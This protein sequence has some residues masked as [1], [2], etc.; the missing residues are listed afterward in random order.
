M[1]IQAHKLLELHKADSHE[2]MVDLGLQAS[3]ATNIPELLAIQQMERESE[4]ERPIMG[5]PTK[6]SIVG[7]VFSTYKHDSR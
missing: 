7:T 2:L 6:H 4:L 1:I 3:S 5:K